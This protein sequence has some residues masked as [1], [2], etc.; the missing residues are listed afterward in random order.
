MS[1]NLLLI[2]ASLAVAETTKQP[3]E[4]AQAIY[5]AIAASSKES[6]IF[7]KGDTCTIEWTPKPGKR[8]IFEDKMAVRNAAFSELSAIEKKIDAGTVD[9]SELARAVKLIITLLKK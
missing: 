2:F 4:H 6:N 3:T 9:N 1:M 5:P 7:C 8:A